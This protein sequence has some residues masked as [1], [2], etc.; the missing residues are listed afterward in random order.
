MH[1]IMFQDV[2]WLVH[3]C[4]N[5]QRITK[6]Q[7]KKAT[8]QDRFW[9]VQRQAREGLARCNRTKT[10]LGLVWSLDYHCWQIQCVFYSILAPSQSHFPSASS[11]KSAMFATAM[12]MFE[13]KLGVKHVSPEVRQREES[14]L[15]DMFLVCYSMILMP[16]FNFWTYFWHPVS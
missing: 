12:F 13:S 11:D 4:T 14:E 9:L 5:F 2:S 15:E 10:K 6:S 16:Y 8:D 7:H 1:L 3:C